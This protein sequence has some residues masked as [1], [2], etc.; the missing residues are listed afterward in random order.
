MVLKNFYKSKLPP[1]LLEFNWSCLK[2][3]NQQWVSCLENYH[4]D[5]IIVI[6][7]SYD[8][9][10]FNLIVFYC[11]VCSYADQP[12]HPFTR[13]FHAL[14]THITRSPVTFM[15]WTPTS[16]V[17]PSL[18]CTDQTHSPVPFCTDHTDLTDMTLMTGLNLILSSWQYYCDKEFLQ[19]INCLLLYCIIVKLKLKW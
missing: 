13:H 9:L 3:E 14:N 4:L 16:H 18:S 12:H 10:M 19:L 6:R 15:H 7:N 1:I 17:H 8:W 5:Y 2:F 11:I